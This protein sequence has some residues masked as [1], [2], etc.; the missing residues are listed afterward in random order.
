MLQLFNVCDK[1]EASLE[2]VNPTTLGTPVQEEPSIECMKFQQQ[3]HM[4]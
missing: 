4:Q 3:N 2:L 1:K